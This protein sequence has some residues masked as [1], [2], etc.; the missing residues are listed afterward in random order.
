VWTAGRPSTNGPA[1]T[2]FSTGRRRGCG[3]SHPGPRFQ[4]GTEARKR[5]TPREG[6]QRAGTTL[7]NLLVLRRSTMAGWI[8]SGELRV[9]QIPPAASAVRPA[10]ST[11]RAAGAIFESTETI[12]RFD[13]G[14]NDSLV[15]V[16]ETASSHTG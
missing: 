11:A 16:A 5:R 14:A 12:A 10:P 9:R 4:R 7:C 8:L 15:V 1:F 13:T 3:R 2:T 6:M